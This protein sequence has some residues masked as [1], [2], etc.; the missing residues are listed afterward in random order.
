[1]KKFSAICIGEILWDSMPLG[2]FLGGAPF[3]V[4]Y[5]LNK[6]G[7]D[8]KVVSCVGDD[9]LGHEA[10]KRM[11]Y[12]GLSKDFIQINNKQKTGFVSVDLGADGI[13]DY[14]IKKPAAWDF[15]TH[16]RELQKALNKV[17]VI[18]FGTLAQRMDTSRK[19]I[20]SI[21]YSSALKVLDLNLRTPFDNKNIVYSS[22]KMA[23]FLKVNIEELH[24]LKDWFD[25]PAENEKALD[26]LLNMFQIKCIAITHGSEGAEFYNGSDHV[27][28]NGIQIDVLDTVGSGDA[29]L[30]ALITGY[31]NQL[32]IQECM[33]YANKLG[34]FVATCYGGTPDYTIR[35]FKNIETLLN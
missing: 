28:S 34:A 33:L 2:L 30:A 15:I 12:N 9:E 17:D 31:M 4:A 19:T 6:L 24:Q 18:V 32:S 5:H 13:P 3:N 7:A 10:L 16:T 35:E 8:L 29:F 27:K 1:M 25:L 22:L 11:S 14:T 21:Q 20:E 23:D 26:K